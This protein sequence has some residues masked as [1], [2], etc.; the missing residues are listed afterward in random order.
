MKTITLWNMKG[1]VGKTTIAFNL[2]TEL[3]AHGAKVLCIDL[4][5][6]SDLTYFFDPEMRGKKMSYPDI[7]QLTEKHYAS[8]KPG[9][10]ISR[11]FKGISY[12]RGSAKH[13]DFQ[14]IDELSH[15]LN[16]VK[17]SYDY[18]II[19]CHPDY[20]MASQNA[21]YASS[22]VLV[23]ILLDGFS[24]GNLNL[25][26]SHLSE[27]ME[28]TG[29]EIE[30]HIIINQITSTKDSRNRLDDLLNHHD[31]PVLD[32]GIRRTSSVTSAISVHK[33]V[34]MHRRKANITSD[35]SDLTSALIA[36]TDRMEAI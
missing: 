21:L 2:G 17:D 20:G 16:A 4:D 10:Y 32:L 1:G 3:A 22:L 33:P 6:Q 9:I 18:C 13:T 24:I 19:D 15:M 36:L 23:P 27:L 31:Y 8:I 7:Y 35:F 34:F 12:V 28:K 29:R 30:W 14:T 25:V 11:R 5:P 26:D